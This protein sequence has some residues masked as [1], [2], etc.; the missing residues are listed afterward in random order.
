MR[1]A[2]VLLGVLLLPVTAKADFELNV[3]I[4]GVDEIIA[5]PGDTFTA[6]LELIVGATD[7]GGYS[8]Q[9]AYDTSELMYVSSTHTGAAP[10]IA[11]SVP[12]D[13]GTTVGQFDGITLPG[14]EAGA[15][16]YEL[17]S[18]TFEVLTPLDDSN[19]DL[20]ATA[21]TVTDANND[22]IAGGTLN[23]ATVVPE[24]G[25]LAALLALGGVVTL[26]RRRTA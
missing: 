25:S 18:I 13:L 17:G 1:I 26:R 9:V 2:A 19:T 3:L 20:I 5:D 14:N 10:L 21:V 7:V 15:G 24:P 16:T 12:S 11:F 23:G 8:F 22:P 4:G 6:T